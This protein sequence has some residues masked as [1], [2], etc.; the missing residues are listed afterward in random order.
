VAKTPASHSSG[1]AALDQGA[2]DR[3]TPMPAAVGW[4]APGEVVALELVA[5]MP[6]GFDHDFGVLTG[7]AVRKACVD[8][9]YGCR[10]ASAAGTC[11]RG[12]R[13]C[14]AAALHRNAGRGYA[15]TWGRASARVPAF[16]A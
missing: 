1:R 13:A 5:P 7:P 12:G 2:R 4:S 9:T 10:L 11:C 6:G 15:T 3:D 8:G 16:V 14:S